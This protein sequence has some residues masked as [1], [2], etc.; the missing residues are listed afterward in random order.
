MALSHEAIKA[1][2]NDKW[3]A[4]LYNWDM[5]DVVNQTILAL[6]PEYRNRTVYPLKR[7]IF[8]AFRQT[9]PDSLKVI[10]LV[11]DPYHDGRATGHA[12]ANEISEDEKL[13]PTLEVFR[14]EWAEDTGAVHEFDPTLMRYVRQGVM[15][16]NT[17]LTVR[18][19]EPKSHTK[20]W[21]KWTVDF[22][23]NYSKEKP[24]LLWILMGKQAQEFQM[25]ITGGH[26]LKTVHPAAETYSGGKSGFY[27][28]KVF[29]K[30]NLQ[31]AK[32]NKP[33]IQW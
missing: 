24:N 2:F 21:N 8:R 26:V 13:S 11:Q 19:G 15:F 22:I 6:Q 10:F 12:M 5:L 29:Y 31:L 32:L 3:T 9:D 1:I 17:A 23:T 14:K 7:N 30:I 4:K 33:M 20:L 28:C 27:G 18:E 25:Y 16:L